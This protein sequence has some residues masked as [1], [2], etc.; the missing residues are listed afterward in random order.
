MSNGKFRV[1]LKWDPILI[2][3]QIFTIQTFWYFAFG[4]ILI[5]GSVFTGTELTLSNIFSYKVSILNDIFT[6]F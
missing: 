6:I 3:A 1:S 4:S 2:I 5:L